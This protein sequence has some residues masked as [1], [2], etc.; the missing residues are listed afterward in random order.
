[1]PPCTSTADRRSWSTPAAP[2]RHPTHARSAR[3]ARP[4]GPSL[5][6][7]NGPSHSASQ[8]SKK[9]AWCAKSEAGHTP[10]LPRR[11]A[12]PLPQRQPGSGNAP[13]Q[14]RQQTVACHHDPT[15]R[16]G[17]PKRQTAA[18]HRH[19]SGSVRPQK[20]S[21]APRA[22]VAK[23]KAA[24]PQAWQTQGPK[25]RHGHRRRQ[26]VELEQARLLR[27]LRRHPEKIRCS[28]QQQGGHPRQ[29]APE[30]LGP[31]RGGCAAALAHSCA[32]LGTIQPIAVYHV[33]RLNRSSLRTPKNRH[34]K[35]LPLGQ[36]LVLG[37]AV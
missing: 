33:G 13:P 2:H 23:T 15:A 27:P 11:M 17:R 4:A 28:P 7:A 22:K 25:H 1:M 34:K 6:K 5:G 26:Q 10:A 24:A 21:K 31:S 29:D 16:P 3:W 18:K 30:P 32:A 20:P 14:R 37:C 9:L 19:P 12:R 35:T 36:G 8:G